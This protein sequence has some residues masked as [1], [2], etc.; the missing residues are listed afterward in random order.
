MPT[1]FS[2]RNMMFIDIGGQ[3]IAVEV[4]R[5]KR[6]KTIGIAVR[7]DGTV[8]VSIPWRLSNARL[9]EALRGRM[10]WIERGLRKIQTMRARFPLEHRYTS[11]ERFWF[12]GQ[13]LAL[14]LEDDV[15]AKPPRVALVAGEMVVTLARPS[16]ERVRNALV[17][18]Y[19]QQ[20]ERVLAERVTYYAAKTGLR[21]QAVE[22][23]A[24]RRRWGDCKGTERVV[25][26]N[27]R[28]MQAPLPVVDYLVVHELAHLREPNHSRR[29]W[30]LVG[31]IAPDFA[32]G[33][34]WLKEWGAPR[35]LLG[36]KGGS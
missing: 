17:T 13:E 4:N 31:S 35:L 27:W 12:L 18:W 29:F 9:E 20:A 25:R 34:K 22:V 28:I 11:G 7:L 14:R 24:W 8:A 33:R 3:R 2:F 5:S 36:D 32:Q 21:P 23:V 15:A 26:F 19:R 16:S 6:R 30:H 1:G 10:T